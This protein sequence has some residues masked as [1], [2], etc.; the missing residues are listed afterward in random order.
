MLWI[1]CL[2]LAM[3]TARMSLSAAERRSSMPSRAVRAAGEL[4]EVGIVAL[5]VVFLVIRPFVAQ[6]FYIPSASMRPTLRENDRII[7]NKLSYWLGQ[8]ARHDVVV[9]RAPRE[10]LA[11]ESSGLSGVAGAAESGS[12]ETDFIKRVIGLPGD[13][14]EIHHGILYVN[15]KAQTEPYCREQP[16][17]ELPPY[18]VPAGKLFVM[19][20]NRN[21]SNDSHRW[22]ALDKRRLVGRAVCI[23]WPPSRAGSIR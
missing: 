2:I 15:G 13:L 11:G 7:V 6:A 4:L 18:V 16:F 10:A 14:I 21:H 23:F 20:D 19:G 3:T 17:Y 8:P 5:A 9:F 22:G 12:E 1:V